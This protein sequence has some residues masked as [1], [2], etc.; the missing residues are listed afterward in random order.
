MNGVIV[1]TIIITEGLKTGYTDR[2][3]IRRRRFSAILNSLDWRREPRYL[4]RK[5]GPLLSRKSNYP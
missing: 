1:E 3:S 4:K 5:I 2:K